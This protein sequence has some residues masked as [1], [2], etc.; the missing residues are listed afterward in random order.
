MVHGSARKFV[1]SRRTDEADRAMRQRHEGQTG[2][3]SARYRSA[4]RPSNAMTPATPARA[5]N[6]VAPPVGEKLAPLAMLAFCAV[7]L[8]Q[9]SQRAD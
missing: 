9:P 8:L 7:A 5:D 1:Y 3:T 2:L 4:I 6:A